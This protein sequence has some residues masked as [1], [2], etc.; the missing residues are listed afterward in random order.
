MADHQEG[1]V[2]DVAI[3]GAGILGCALSVAFG[4]QG[5]SV[6]LIER[7]LSEPNRI[8]GELL[9]PGG[10]QALE[11]L[12]MKD[13]LEGIDAIPVYGYECIYHGQRVNIPYLQQDNGSRY[14][15][16]SFHHGKFIMK[17]REAARKTKGVTII[18]ATAKDLIRSKSDQV[19]GVLASP[20]TAA[21]GAQPNEYFAHLTVSADGYASNFRKHVVS[22]KA[23]VRSTFVGLELKDIV[24][25]AP[26]HGHVIM[27]NNPPVLLYQ[28]GTHDTRA[29]IDMP[30]LPPQGQLREYLLDV[31]LPDLPENI[32]PAFKKAVEGDRLPSMP[33]SFLPAT[34]NNQPGFILLGDAMNMRH[35]LTG[36]GMTVAFN[37]VV[38]ISQLLS[39]ANVPD[40]SDTNLVLEQMRLFHWDR[41]NLSSVVNILAQALYSLFAAN[42]DKLRVLQRGCFQYFQR[43]GE[44]IDGPVGL[45]SGI[46][47]K[48]MTL[49]YHFFS[50]ALYSIGI[51]IAGVTPVLGWPLAIVNA[52]LVFWKAC[53]VIFP[54]IFAEMFT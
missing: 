30:R 28:I 38:L 2:Y 5:R 51:M 9:Q 37:D 48:P 54:Y 18:E 43:G 41:K 39:P 15:G 21:K 14:E 36:G 8:V 27:G 1:K 17:L 50:V 25:P 35:P 26:N 20:K 32:R 16:R 31:V 13:C 34:T 40:F 24:L 19:I 44:C 11:K 10:V 42:D 33:N 29:L 7:D 22:R 46:T 4:N 53:V 3:V 52:V 23:E 47:K 49:F 45:L 12:G 6:L